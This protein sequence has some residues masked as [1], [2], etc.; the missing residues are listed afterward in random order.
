[1]VPADDPAPWIPLIA[2]TNRGLLV[3]HTQDKPEPIWY[4]LPAETQLPEWV[5]P[6]A[7]RRL[8]FRMLGFSHQS[9]L[10]CVL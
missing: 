2:G 3:Q 8:K 10:Y 4:G 6:K 5:S 9:N 7:G 1:M